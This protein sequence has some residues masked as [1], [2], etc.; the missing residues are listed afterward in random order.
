MLG[1]AETVELRAGVRTQDLLRR[2]AV[3]EREQDGDEAAHDVGVAV[4]LE[5]Q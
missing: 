1:E 2:A 3:E 5:V 4:A